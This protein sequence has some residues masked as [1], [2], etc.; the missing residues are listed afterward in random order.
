[1]PTELL[2]SCLI[3]VW[4]LMMVALERRFPYRAGQR[5]FRKAIWTDFAWYNITFALL[6]GWVVHT[7]VIPLLDNHTSL[8]S[9]GTLTNLPIWGQVLISLFS[10]D[11][12]IY[13]FHRTMHRS[14]YLWRIHEAHHSPVE[15]DWAGGNRSHVIESIITGTAEFAPIA[16]FM[17]PEVALYKGVIDAWWGMWIHA[18]IDV[19]AGFLNYFINGPELHRWHHS[20]DVYDVNFGTKFSFW[21]WIF[22]TAYW[23]KGTKPT[24]YG[25]DDPFP[26]NI[27][28]Q[29]WFA[30]RPFRK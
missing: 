16:L 11:L 2:S 6:M 4:A 26:D 14:K 21:D 12:F 29:Q 18:N 25:I 15:V 22:G 7:A 3:G 24:R 23:P 20:K 27:F 17:S 8:R 13:I 28:L 19:R 9:W 1:M 10:H 30:F 5:L